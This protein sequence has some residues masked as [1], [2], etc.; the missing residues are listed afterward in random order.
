MLHFPRG[1]PLRCSEFHQDEPVNSP[2]LH[3][4]GREKA[5]MALALPLCP[6]VQNERLL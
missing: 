4:E 6:Y 3:L 2:L 5:G 1:S